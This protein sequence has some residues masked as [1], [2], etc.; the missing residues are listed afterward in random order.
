ME[1]IRLTTLKSLGALN[2]DAPKPFIICFRCRGNGPKSKV[3][4]S[5]RASVKRGRGLGP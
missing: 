3:I 2:K 5:L 1:A 4:P